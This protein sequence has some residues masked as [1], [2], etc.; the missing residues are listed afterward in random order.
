MPGLGCTSIVNS[1]AGEGAEAGAGDPPTEVEEEEEATE[2]AAEAAPRGP[3]ANL[4]PRQAVGAD[5]LSY[6]PTQRLPVEVAAAPAPGGEVVWEG[7]TLVGVGGCLLD[8]LTWLPPSF[9]IQPSPPLTQ[10][11]PPRMMI[12]PMHFQWHKRNMFLTFYCKV[13]GPEGLCLNRWSSRG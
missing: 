5:E 9:T 3:A 10:P 6:A 4:P 8:S 2:C 1:C 12:P 7:N 13:P 11:P